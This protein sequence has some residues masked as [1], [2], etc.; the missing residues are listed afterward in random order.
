MRATSH[1]QPPTADLTTPKLLH[2]NRLEP[3]A[4]FLPSQDC[5]INLN[6]HWDFSYFGTPQEAWAALAT[7]AITWDKIQ[8]PGHWQLQGFGAPQYTNVRYPFPVDP[9]NVPIANA[10]GVYQRLVEIPS[11]WT[12]NNVIRLRFDG[13]DSSYHVYLNE[14]LV[15]YS[16]GSRNVAEFDVTSLVDATQGKPLRLVVIVYQWCDGSY[17]EDQ[18][19][20]WLSGIFRDVQVLSF[21]AA[22]HIEDYKVVTDLDDQYRDATLHVDVKCDASISEAM[23]IHFQLSDLYNGSIISEDRTNFQASGKDSSS[24]C[25]QTLKITNPKK[26]TAESPYLYNLG[27]RLFNATG[28]ELQNI[29][30]RVGFRKVE[31]IKGNITVNGVPILINGVNRHDHHPRLGR[32]VPLDFIRRDLVLMKQNNINAVRCSHYPNTPEF[33]NICD[34][35]GL[36]VMDEADL[37][38]HGFA[39]AVVK[40]QNRPDW[41]QWNKIKPQV[42]PLAANYTS[43]NPEWQDAYLD[44]MQRLVKSNKNHPSIIIWSLGNEAFYGC[45]HKAM[46]DWSKQYD[47]TRPIHYEGDKNAAS[48]DMYSYMYPSVGKLAHWAEFEGDDFTK[49]IVV[50][51][52]AH[53][54]GN[55]PGNLKEYQDIFRTKRR[56]QGGYVWEWQ[57][58]GLINTNQNG[59]EYF[60]YG[61]DFGEKLHDSKYCMD[62]IVTSSH[63][64][65]P[66]LIEYKKVIEPIEVT[67]K[68]DTLEIRNWYDFIDLGHCAVNWKIV[69]CCG[70]GEDEVVIASG[71]LPL[72]N[73]CPGQTVAIPSPFKELTNLSLQPGNYIYGNLDFTL[74]DSTSWANVGHEIAWAQFELAKADYKSP[75]LSSLAGRVTVDRSVPNRLVIAG[76]NFEI[77]FDTTWGQISQWLANGRSLLSENGGPKLGIWRPPTDND[78]CGHAL[79]WQKHGLD[80]LEIMDVTVDSTEHDERAEVTVKYRLG[81]PT[82]LSGF[83]VTTIYTIDAAGGLKLGVD[84]SPITENPISLPR[85]GIDLELANDFERVKW[86]GKGPHQS[87]KDSDASARQGVFTS[88]ISDL[89]FLYEIPQEN[90]NRSQVKWVSIT[91]AYSSG[92][93]ARFKDKTF[94]FQASHYCPEDITEAKHIYQLERQ[95]STYVRL[96]LDHHGLGN[97]SI[98]PFVLPEYE[99]KNKP[100]S[101]TIELQLVV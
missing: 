45:N 101:F 76:P 38:C 83:S 29:C 25:H 71:T 87:Y 92:I 61:G 19:Q 86:H 51:E 60:G 13:V 27:I 62:G 3:R 50:C 28:H 20:W 41:T 2:R 23:S 46:Y 49:P 6:G 59:V 68:G 75:P 84:V 53:S 73:I 32:A 77:H 24:S 99:L 72:P 94:S 52:Y 98:S 70:P 79:Q 40:D 18:D 58:H 33:Y 15:G 81:A 21:P 39:E 35:L 96:D 22:A 100:I 93:C 74:K 37:E 82:V 97:A 10:T 42:V 80:A 14:T 5:R 85:I 17:I 47:P 1:F 9:P 65:T 11:T 57:D 95:T 34:E 64:P 30:Q 54:K 88:K 12:G 26:W 78:L 44:R 36:W 16:Q 90:G 7:D 43:N 67:K 4:Y 91:D 56:I 31:T 69:K 66:G 89:D 55:G 8:V 48:A 63:D